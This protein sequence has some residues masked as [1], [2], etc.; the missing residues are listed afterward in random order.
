MNNLSSLSVI[1]NLCK[2]YGM[3]PRRDKGQNFLV[4]PEV[5][6]DVVGVAALSKQDT[7]LEIGPGFGVLTQKLVEHAGEVVALE[8][9]AVLARHI[10]ELFRDR[11]N[12]RVIHGDALRIDPHIRGSYK[13]VANIPY[14]ITSRL[15]RIFLER[16]DHPDLLVL[17]IQ[18]EVAER[19]V[20]EPGG[21]SLLSVMV[22]YYATPEIVRIVPRASF[23]PEPEVD[24]AILRIQPHPIPLLKGEGVESPFSSKEKVG[25]RSE[26]FFRIVRMG[27]ASRRKQLVNNLAAGL[28]QSKEIIAAHLRLLG[29]VP[30]VRAQEL[31][32]DQWKELVHRVLGTEKLKN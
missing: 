3:T 10:T 29:F 1:Q 24:S 23:W 8:A 30:T 28:K 31:S 26:D 21:M 5:L 27:F 14:Q 4:D 13:L 20:A 19:I 11:K 9:D 25:M 22:Q 2:K 12:L 6:E 18:K 17:M 7:V 15:L 16:P 32:V